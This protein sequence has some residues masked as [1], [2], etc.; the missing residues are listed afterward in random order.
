MLRILPSISGSLSR[1]AV[2]ER[3]GATSPVASLVTAAVVLLTLWALTPLVYFVPTCALAGIV[4]EA[5]L[6]LVDFEQV[7]SIYYDV[8][9]CIY[10]YIYI[11]YLH[12]RFK[13]LAMTLFSK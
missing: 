4:I 11:W 7:F 6:S 9:I 3:T 2:N 12:S 13:G 1:T 10:I 8:P 5:A